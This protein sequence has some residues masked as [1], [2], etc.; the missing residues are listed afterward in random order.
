MPV[1]ND[2]KGHAKMIDGQLKRALNIPTAGKYVN[3]NTAL[4]VNCSQDKEAIKKILRIIDE[5]DAI[6]RYKWYNI[7]CDLTSNELERLLY[8]RGNLCFF[9][10]ESMDKFFIMPYAL[11]GT[12]DFYGR[13]NT[14]HPLPFA[15]GEDLGESIKAS[16]SPDIKF[17]KKVYQSQKETLSQIKLKVIK[18]VV[19]IN[20]ITP[21]LLTGS[22]VIIRDYTNQIP[23]TNIPRWILNDPLIDIMSDYI[24]FLGT[25]LL[26]G[27]GISSI[28]VNST[29]EKDE[30]KKIGN[31]VYN[32]AVNKNP[33]VAMTSNVPFQELTGGARNKPE[34]YLMAFQSL[35]NLRLSTLG[36]ANGGI[37]EKKQHILESENAINYST[38]MSAFEDG[39]KNRQEACNIINS[40]WGLDLWCDPSEA[41]LGMDEDGDGE[42]LDR[43]ESQEPPVDGTNTMSEGGEE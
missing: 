4:L 41:S 18:E 7:P 39:L 11:E 16:D 33:Y 26:L 23:Q 36:I 12:L 15:N 28:R 22:A 43:G 13:Y 31:S 27:T 38:V 30:V 35:D 10:M 25:N 29:D 8:Y 32:A 5:Q 6:N 19:D 21:E 1:V 40:I 37:F 20:E 9:Y 2:G 14:I 34:D 17:K 24:P 42:A 3:E